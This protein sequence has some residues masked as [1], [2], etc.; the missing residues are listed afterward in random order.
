MN[1][2]AGLAPGVL[3]EALGAERL[4]DEDLARRGDAHSFALLYQRHLPALYRYLSSRLASRE[5]AED[6]TSDVFQRAWRSR[7]AFSGQGSMRAW[8]FAIA[9][10]MLADHYRRTPIASALEPDTL[11]SL[12]DHE[13]PPDETVI[14]DEFAKRVRWLIQQLNQEQQEVLRLRFA[15]E[16][17]YGEI[18]IAIGKREDAVKKIAYRALETLRRS[19]TDA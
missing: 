18:A 9:R 14:K 19:I 1:Q 8:L 15:A 10:R 4:A 13:T 17:T 3:A 16:L 11:H 12:V 6:L 7:G 5:E 2:S